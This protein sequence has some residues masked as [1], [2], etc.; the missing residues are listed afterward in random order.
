MARV[1]DIII[2]PA[3]P[4]LA[5][6]LS[7]IWNRALGGRFPLTEWLWRQNVEGDPNW[8]PGDALVARRAVGA[9]VGFALTRRFQ[10][11][12]EPANADLTALRDLGWIMAL[13]VAP[14][15]RG[16][17]IGGRLIAAAEGRL[18]AA[19]ATRCDLGG[20][21]GHLLPGPPAGDERAARFWARHGYRPER[22][23]HDLVRD[24]ADWTPPAPPAALR[25]GDWRL[26]PARAGRRARSSTSWRGPS[27]AAGATTWPTPSRAARRSRT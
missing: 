3:A 6:D 4:D 9:L 20:S 27:P 14:E 13:A 16:R 8:R 25:S 11:G 2:E 22:Q 19:G 23:V 12:D 1:V 26:G 15:E 24:L 17:G 7:A 10:G 5:P 21:V 18:R